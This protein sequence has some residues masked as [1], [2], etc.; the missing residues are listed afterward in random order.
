MKK[1]FLFFWFLFAA[2]YGEAQAPLSFNYQGIARNAAGQPLSN[3][4]MNIKLSIH[5]G[6]AAGDIE[7]AE[8]RTI[9]TNAYGLFQV[10]VGS[11]GAN[12]TQGSFS[13]IT[14]HAALKFIQTEI[15]LQGNQTYIDLGTV[16]LQSVPYALHSREAASLKFPSEHSSAQN[17]FQLKLTNISNESN[18]VAA[19][20]NSNL[21]FGVA[22]YSQSGTGIK[23]SS[24]YGTAFEANGNLYLHGGNMQPGNGKVLTSDA[25]GNAN[26]QTNLAK[27]FSF[28]ID[29]TVASFQAKP[30]LKI[31]KTFS[32]GTTAI[33]ELKNSRGMGIYALSDSDFAVRATSYSPTHSGI[34]G[35]NEAGGNGV[36]GNAY[37]AATGNGIYGLAGSGNASAGVLGDGES[38]SIGVKGVSTNFFGIVGTSQTHIGVYGSSDSNIGV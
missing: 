27:G 15:L 31:H 14:W 10:A 11:A 20:F 34:F 5:S 35:G 18:S 36:I 29:T 17:D 4:T 23:A 38:N 7:Y 3:Q 19:S 1:S 13:A 21:G 9:T 12:N 22:G 37:D 6:T 8:V 30:L 32:S 28:P 24:D 16:P 26:W 25:F 33:F 2:L